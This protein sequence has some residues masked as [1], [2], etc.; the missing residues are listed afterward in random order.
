[1]TPTSRYCQSAHFIPLNAADAIPVALWT[2]QSRGQIKILSRVL[3]Q[4]NVIHGNCKEL[5]RWERLEGKTLLWVKKNAL[6]RLWSGDMKIK[7]TFFCFII[8]W[9]F[10]PL[11]WIKSA[12]MCILNHK[13]NH[14]L[15]KYAKI[16]SARGNRQN[17]TDIYFMGN[18][19]CVQIS[20]RLKIFK[21]KG[22]KEYSTFLWLAGLENSQWPASK[23]RTLFVT[24]RTFIKIFVLVMKILHELKLFKDLKS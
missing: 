18:L 16:C 22:R 6:H 24:W 1:M 14:I 13:F 20:S 23:L 8:L 2:A 7:P 15:I 3:L 4:I 9:Y 12:N 17:I 21:Q 11:D 5:G 10:L 19:P